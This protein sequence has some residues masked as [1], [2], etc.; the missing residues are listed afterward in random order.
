MAT[1]QKLERKDG[2]RYRVLIRRKGHASITKVFK[3]KRDADNWAREME[4]SAENL[5][6]YPSVDARKRT[7]A[8]AIDGF[9]GSYDKRDGSILGRLAWWKA[10]YGDLPLAQF[11]QSTIK[12]G[13][14][15]LSGRQ[16]RRAAGKGKTVSLGRAKTSA[17]V[18]R[19]LVAISV[20]MQWA[21][22]AT[23]WLTK[24]PA[25]GIRRRPEPRGRVRWLTD[26]ERQR[27]LDACDRSEWQ[28]LGLLVRL[29]LST[30]ARQAELLNLRWADIDP[31]R[32]IAYVGKTKN[33]EPRMLPLVAPVRELLGKKPRPLHTSLVFY[34]PSRPENPFT[35]RPYW[36]AAIEQAEIKDFRFHDLRHSCASYLAMAGASHVEI[37]EVLGHKTLQMV[38]RYSHLSS[39]HKQALMERV[40]GKLVE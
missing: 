37:A 7:V 10:E 20:V 22:E 14:Q 4:G 29:A 31:K 26:D 34:S 17:T 39:A 6:A 1:I 38:K 25:R 35:F 33:D 9:M 32:G 12:A 40:T 28:D 11:R 13:L 23:S 3:L 21:I 15:A 8:D 24:N 5:E 18:N 30:G 27:L 19:Y 2:A 36:E 16:A